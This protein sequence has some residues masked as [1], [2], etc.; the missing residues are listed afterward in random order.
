MIADKTGFIICLADY[1]FLEFAATNYHVGE[2]D[3]GGNLANS[4]FKISCWQKIIN[5][6]GAV[7]ERSLLCAF[8]KHD[9]NKFGDALS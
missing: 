6:F 5:A 3:D 2:N 9:I 7:L 8:R 1:E 4:R